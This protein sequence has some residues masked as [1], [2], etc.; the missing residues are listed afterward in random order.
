MT[1]K[2]ASFPSAGACSPA[3]AGTGGPKPPFPLNRATPHAGREHRAEAAPPGPLQGFAGLR[4]ASLTFARR[5]T[6]PWWV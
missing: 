2:S 5:M 1:L 6:F 3:P 4:V